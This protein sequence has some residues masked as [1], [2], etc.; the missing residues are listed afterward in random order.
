M[1]LLGSLHEEGD[2]GVEKDTV[3]A[4]R[5]YCRA[6]EVG[7]AGAAKFLEDFLEGEGSVVAENIVRVTPLCPISRM[8]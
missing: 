6:I 2:D 4:V 7:H 1:V 3:E 8:E 5:L